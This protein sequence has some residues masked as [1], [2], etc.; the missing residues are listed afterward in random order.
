MIARVV[1]EGGAIVRQYGDGPD[2]PWWSIT[3]TVTAA[4]ALTLVNE[5]RLELDA[6]VHGRAFTLRQLLQHRA[7]LRDYGPLPAYQQAVEQREDAWPPAVM[8]ERAKADQPAYESGKGWGYSNIGYYFVR[9]LLEQTA[10][11]P[12]GQVLEQRVLQPLALSG[13]RL[14]TERGE[15]A[16][17]YDPGWVYHGALIGP[18][19]QA[20]LLLDRLLS[21][22]LLPSDLL[23]DMLDGVLLP[24]LPPG[25]V[26]TSVRYGLGI[27]ICRT[28]AGLE[29]TGHNGG[30]PGSVVGV[31]HS[32][33]RTAAA[34]ARSEDL[35][36]VEQSCVA[37]L[38]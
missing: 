36:T 4:A 3:K 7:G 27:A 35:T 29:A 26:W 37:M 19:A 1:V 9:E 20:A 30:G 5:G 25:R 12:L 33:G 18:L 24:D 16:P 31:F 8:L 34:F 14:A 22:Q 23:T 28:A 11:Q 32:R 15:L 38:M 21:G 17:D 10:G 6:P 2:V 13:V